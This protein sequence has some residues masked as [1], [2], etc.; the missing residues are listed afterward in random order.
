M[1]DDSSGST[2]GGSPLV[3]VLYCQESA[4]WVNVHDLLRFLPPTK[5]HEVR[6]I[7]ASEETGF[8]HLYLVT[9]QIVTES[10]EPS[11]CH[12]LQ[13]RILHKVALTQAC[14]VFRITYTDWDAE[15]VTLIPA[16]Y[17]LESAPLPSSCYCPEL[18]THQISAGPTLYAMVFRPHDYLPGRKYPTI[19]NVY[20]GPEVQLV[21]NTF[22]G[23]RQ[24]R[25]HMLAARG[26][27]VVAIDSRGSQH[28]GLNWESH[29]KGRMGTVELQDQVEVLRWLA[30]SLKCIDLTRVA[31]HGWSYGGYLSLMGLAHHPDV[32]KI[33]IAGA[34]VTN[35]SLYDTGYTERYMG[36]PENNP[37][38]YQEGSVLNYV[39]KFPEEYRYH[40]E[41][42]AR[43]SLPRL[44]GAG[45]LPMPI[46][47]PKDS[48]SE[49]RALFGQNDYIDIL[50]NESL[51][52]TKIL[53]RV[54]SWLRG[55]SG[56][57]YQLMIRKRKVFFNSSYRF[58]RPT[59][60]EQLNKRIRFL[61]KF[62]NRKTRTGYSDQ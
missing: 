58:V 32:F 8:R 36:L 9:A 39:N 11:E 38:G 33:A 15:G 44:R 52:P 61:H 25:M 7:W 34:P 35:W 5:S 50:G 21:S 22:K 31:I 13:P 16:G 30:N 53:Y 49:K 18:F 1:Y 47:R 55:V 14:E 41:K 10:V 43:G 59:K 26:Y 2:D 62:L 51:H 28:R 24:L 56:N 29:L 12:F 42:V 54:P 46:Y 45:R 57:E 37:Q 6:F 23:M 60:W 48:W 17:L 19:L 3:Q 20:G 4:V 40:S 27:C